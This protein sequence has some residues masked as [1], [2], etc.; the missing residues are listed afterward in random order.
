MRYSSY[1]AAMATTLGA[2]P[3]SVPTLPVVTSVLPSS[4]AA[5]LVLASAV[6]AVAAGGTAPTSAWVTMFDAMSGGTA[7]LQKLWGER[8]FIEN[9]LPHG[10]K[11]NCG[12]NPQMAIR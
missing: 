4:A 5:S 3:P 2:L 7:A 11:G 12:A 8:V 6:T 1:F 9:D 10:A